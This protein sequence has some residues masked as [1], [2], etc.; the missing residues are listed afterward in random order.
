MVFV[1]T[2]RQTSHTESRRGKRKALKKKWSGLAACSQGQG[3][4]YS[5]KSQIF[6]KLGRYNFLRGGGGIL[7]VIGGHQFFL[8]PLSACEKILAPPLPVCKG[9][10]PPPCAFGEKILAPPFGVKDLNLPLL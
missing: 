1:T 7:S 8:P 5:G 4:I 9:I 6:N 2:L 10:L 3:H